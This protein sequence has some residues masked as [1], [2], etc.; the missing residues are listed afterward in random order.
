[1]TAAGHSDKQ[2]AHNGRHTPPRRGARRSAESGEVETGYSAEIAAQLGEASAQLGARL[3]D[4]A[5][6]HSVAEVE[7]VARG[8]SVVA[9]GM[10]EGMGG[11]TEWLRAAGHAGPLSGHASV[12]A[13]RLAHVSKELTRLAEAIEKARQDT[14]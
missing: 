1:M 13:D 3:V 7:Q 5:V 8:F 14:P 6:A 11:V 12:V 4:P 10:A 9:D 2:R